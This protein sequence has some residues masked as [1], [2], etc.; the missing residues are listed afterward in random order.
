VLRDLVVL[1]VPYDSGIMQR[2]AMNAL[3]K[4]EKSGA[5]LSG[6]APGYPAFFRSKTRYVSGKA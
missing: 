5:G 2:N 3:H 4:S 1:L 6:S